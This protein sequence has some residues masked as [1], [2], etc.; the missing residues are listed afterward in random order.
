MPLSSP[1]RSRRAPASREP[2]RRKFVAA[3]AA[4]PSGD[5]GLASVAVLLLRAA[6]NPR[7]LGIEE[8]ALVDLIGRGDPRV[9]LRP[10]LRESAG[11]HFG[12]GLRHV[13]CLRLRKQCFPFV[14]R[15]HRAVH[16]STAMQIE[17]IAAA[18]P[19][20]IERDRS[21]RFAGKPGSDIASAPS[22]GRSQIPF[23]VS[24]L[25]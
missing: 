22:S 8:F 5:K 10:H 24:P 25:P 7:E 21:S 17:R 6:L 20:E 1:E 16:A 13:S 15:Q 23:Q 2:C 4:H 3:K 11:K 12:S 19:S 18:T 14:Q 9:R